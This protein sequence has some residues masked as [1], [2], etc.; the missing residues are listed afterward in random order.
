MTVVHLKVYLN[1]KLAY[2]KVQQVRG[3]PMKD[4]EKKLANLDGGREFVEKKFGALRFST[5]GTKVQ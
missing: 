1:T 3:Y 4:K 2:S 5:R